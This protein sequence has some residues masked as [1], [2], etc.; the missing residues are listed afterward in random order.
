MSNLE[1]V[2]ILMAGVVIGFM[3]AIVVGSIHL[4]LSK[5]SKKERIEKL[6]QLVAFLRGDGDTQASSLSGFRRQVSG[7]V[8][9]NCK[10][11]EYLSCPKHEFVFSGWD[12]GFLV[13]K[14]LLFE[15]EHCEM[16]ISKKPED[17]DPKE[18]NAL[19]ELGIIEKKQPVKKAGKK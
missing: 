2:L 14:L 7:V 19:I 5:P 4:K 1:S 8:E 15:C 18:L 3:L 6:E 10:L 17:L 16:E 9:E 13:N 12:D 11:K